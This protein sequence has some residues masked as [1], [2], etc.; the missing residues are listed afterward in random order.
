M[1]IQPFSVWGDG[2]FFQVVELSARSDGGDMKG[3]AGDLQSCL[4]HVVPI[5]SSGAEAFYRW[6]QS[7]HCVGHGGTGGI[8]IKATVD[9]TTLVQQRLQPAWVGPGPGGGKES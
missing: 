7:D 3:G 6:M 1:L 5:M 8:G 4:E 9:L 2:F